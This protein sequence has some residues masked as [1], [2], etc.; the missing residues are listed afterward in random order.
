M[1]RMLLAAV[2]AGLVSPPAMAEITT[3]KVKKIANQEIT[4]RAPEFQGQRGL[5]GVPGPQG[6]MGPQGLTGPQ[7]PANGPHQ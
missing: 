7:G 1:K 5:Q 3:A 6:A 4:R 2:I